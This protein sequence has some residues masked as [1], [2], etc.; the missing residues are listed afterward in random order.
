M[1]KGKEHFCHSLAGNGSGKFV[2]RT[3]YFRSFGQ[4]CV[5]Q[6]WMGVFGFFPFDP[7]SAEPE[8]RY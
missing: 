8:R 1:L 3:A 2:G 6:I 7:D 5:S 4:E